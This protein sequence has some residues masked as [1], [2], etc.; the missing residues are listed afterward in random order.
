MIIILPPIVPYAIHESLLRSPCL[1]TG[2]LAMTSFSISF[3]L[4]L[5]EKE[6]NVIARNE[7]QSD[8]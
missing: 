7:E 6:I 4:Q 5:K 2:N 3:S 8:E 1:T